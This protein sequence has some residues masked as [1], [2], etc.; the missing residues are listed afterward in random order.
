MIYK[1]IVKGNSVVLQGDTFPP[2]GTEVEV[3]PKVRID[4]ADTVC[5][6][7]HDD[8]SPEEIIRE[9]SHFRNDQG[10]RI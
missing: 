10:V 4:E 5:G 3:I 6:T 8:R 7:W 1:G 9:I 2:E